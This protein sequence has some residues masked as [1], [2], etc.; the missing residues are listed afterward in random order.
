[1]IDERFDV[2]FKIARQVVVF[3]QDAVLQRLMPA[4]DLALCLRMV[5]SAANVPHVSLPWAK[6]TFRVPALCGVMAIA[7]S[8][9][10]G[11]FHT[12]PSKAIDPRTLYNYE[13]A[14]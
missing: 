12:P 7:L 13:L 10:S 9:P 4:F 6:F 8:T 5:G 2:G 11:P 14:H 1:M 3:L